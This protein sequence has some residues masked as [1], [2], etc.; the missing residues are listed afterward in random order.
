MH[1]LAPL[2]EFRLLLGVERIDLLVGVIAPAQ[3]D[4]PAIRTPLA[5]RCA[6]VGPSDARYVLSAKR[7]EPGE[8]QP[9]CL[10]IDVLE[11]VAD[12]KLCPRRTLTEAPSEGELRF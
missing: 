11:R 4:G 10:D 9:C 8:G 12:F 3:P 2:H 1:E 5:K 6:N 7:K